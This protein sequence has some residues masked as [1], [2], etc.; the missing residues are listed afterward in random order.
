MISVPLYNQMLSSKDLKESD[1][2][3]K[4]I[5]S[6]ASRVSGD[7]YFDDQVTL[8]ETADGWISNIECHGKVIFAGTLT[9]EGWRQAMEKLKENIAGMS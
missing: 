7:S 8:D 9:R 6:L 2:L 4:E 3:A 5:A 1:K